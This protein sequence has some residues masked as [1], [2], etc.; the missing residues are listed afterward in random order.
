MVYY[1]T[2]SDGHL[3]YMGK[4]KFENEDLIKYAFPN[5]LWFHADD[6]SSAHVYIRLSKDE[7]WEKID[8]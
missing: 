2:S 5:D 4:D 3:I 7:D 6:Y 8:Q 1:F